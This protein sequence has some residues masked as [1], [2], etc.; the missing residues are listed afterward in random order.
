MTWVTALCL[1]VPL[2]VPLALA[3]IY[4]VRCASRSSGASRRHID[5][6]A[7]ALRQGLVEA[8]LPLGDAIRYAARKNAAARRYEAKL[9]RPDLTPLKPPKTAFS[10]PPE[11]DAW[12]A[13]NQAR[14]ENEISHLRWAFDVL[15]GAEVVSEEKRV[16][17]ILLY[18][19]AQNA[20]YDLPVVEPK[21]VLNGSPTP[22]S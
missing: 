5:A 18:M 21:V 4:A 10:D 2:S 15:R 17:A 16:E 19:N 8:V 13:R 7:A 3:L 11:W 9:R 14:D 1:S 12:V 22:N 20:G 6:D